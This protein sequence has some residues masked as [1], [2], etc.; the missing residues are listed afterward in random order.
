MDDGTGGGTGDNGDGAGNSG[1]NGDGAGNGDNGN[2]GGNGDNGNGDNGN[3]GDGG[4]NNGGDNNEVGV[5]ETRFG[6]L[7]CYWDDGTFYVDIYIEFPNDIVNATL[8]LAVYERLSDE[9]IAEE[10]FEI[11]D[12]GY[13]CF[14]Y[15]E[16]EAPFFFNNFVNLIRPNCRLLAVI[17]GENA[18]GKRFVSETFSCPIDLQE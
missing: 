4:N 18:N 7:N 8:T 10:T 1:D 9:N 3:G 16:F 14:E 12:I 13:C 17:S 15:A 11:E 6:N 2:G 5:L